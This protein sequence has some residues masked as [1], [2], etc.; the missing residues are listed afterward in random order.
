MTI[1]LDDW[2]ASY[3]TI[4]RT[5]A[6]SNI[7]YL[8]ESLFHQTYDPTRAPVNDCSA[9]AVRVHHFAHVQCQCQYL[10]TSTHGACVSPNDVLVDSAAKTAF[11]VGLQRWPLAVAQ[12]GNDR[13]WWANTDG[14]IYHQ[15]GQLLRRR[16]FG[17]S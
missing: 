7:G 10:S 17:R 4:W 13:Q 12:V 8:A 15:A 3:E 11:Q 16:H 14:V 1:P 9:F 5:T 6:Y 2:K